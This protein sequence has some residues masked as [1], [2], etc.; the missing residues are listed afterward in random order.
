MVGHL[1]YR[2]DHKPLVYRDRVFGLDTGCCRGGR[3]TGLLLPEFKLISVPAR[4]NHWELSRQ[5]YLPRFGHA[6]S[7]SVPKEEVRPEP[8][9][10][11]ETLEILED[12]LADP[13]ITEEEKQDVK[14][15]LTEQKSAEHF[16]MPLYHY[17]MKEHD[18][19]MA[20]L[21]VDKT[22]AALSP[23]EQGKRY[24][25]RVDGHPLSV[26]LHLARHG[27]LDRDAIR[28]YFRS[29]AGFL[30][31]LDKTELQARL[32]REFPPQESGTQY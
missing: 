3:L 12:R 28:R 27:E 20:E 9:E 32:L 10:G 5:V 15:R 19:V 26:L 24:A 11:W 17:V 21:R 29:P 1:T 22:F 30:K 16:L 13:E 8:K 6:V 31:F 7:Q 14:R 2:P 25:A 23:R 4:A 18:S